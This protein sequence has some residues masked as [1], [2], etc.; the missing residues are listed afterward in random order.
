MTA[1]AA[2]AGV[3]ERGD[4]HGRKAGAEGRAA[5]EVHEARSGEERRRSWRPFWI[6]VAVWVGWLVFLGAMAWLRY[7]E[8]GL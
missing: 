1:M 3:G 5:G 8:L 2:S 4:A 6:V 7:Q